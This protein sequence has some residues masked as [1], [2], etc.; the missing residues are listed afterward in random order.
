[1]VEF[2]VFQ[3]SVVRDALLPLSAHSSGT[4]SLYI[5]ICGGG[6][7]GPHSD[8]SRV[9]VELWSQGSRPNPPQAAEP[10]G[11]LYFL[12][13]ESILL[14]FVAGAVSWILIKS[15]LATARHPFP[16]ACFFQRMS[17]LKTSKLKHK[18]H[19]AMK[20]LTEQSS[21][22]WQG[23]QIWRERLSK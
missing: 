3:T 18:Q 21:A 4:M 6:C 13:R 14:V 8:L 11:C 2:L 7:P 12:L 10:P 15:H 5:L 22:S 20:P 16:K 17:F 1:M 9:G 19:A 23:G